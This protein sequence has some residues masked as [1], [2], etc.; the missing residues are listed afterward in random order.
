MTV[1]FKETLSVL[2]GHSLD[3]TVQTMWAL[4][5]TNEIIMRYR[6]NLSLKAGIQEK[7]K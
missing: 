4:Q 6:P 5:T 7:I 3:Y 1:P 2:V